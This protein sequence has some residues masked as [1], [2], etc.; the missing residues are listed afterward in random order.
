MSLISVAVRRAAGSRSTSRSLDGYKAVK[1]A[2]RQPD[3]HVIEFGLLCQEAVYGFLMIGWDLRPRCA[4]LCPAWLR[5]RCHW[6]KQLVLR[7]LSNFETTLEL[8]LCDSCE[9]SLQQCFGMHLTCAPVREH[10]CHGRTQQATISVYTSTLRSHSTLR[11]ALPG[12]GPHDPLVRLA[13]SGT[14][15]VRTA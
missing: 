5:N 10:S 2:L 7:S 9:S 6:T 12:D 4:V 8:G 3:L 11:P 15:P 14:R 1:R 13:Q